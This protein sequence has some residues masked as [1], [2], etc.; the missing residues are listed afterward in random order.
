MCNIKTLVTKDGVHEFLLYIYIYITERVPVVYCFE[1]AILL[2]QDFLYLT[3]V[4][5]VPLV[6]H[7]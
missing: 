6:S 3:I 5:F 7:R 2:H 4:H 1:E